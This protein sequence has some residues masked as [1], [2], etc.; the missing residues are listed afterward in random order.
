M[1]SASAALVK[2]DVFDQNLG[3]RRAQWA[4]KENLQSFN[5]IVNYGCSRL[6]VPFED[7]YNIYEFDKDEAGEIIKTKLNSLDD[8]L[9]FGK[10]YLII[11]KRLGND[12]SFF[13]CYVSLN[14]ALDADAQVP[15]C[16]ASHLSMLHTPPRSNQSQVSTPTSSQSSIFNSTSN[17]VSPNASR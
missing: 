12:L 17:T 14:F 11:N 10:E 9:Q 6:N 8:V 7:T 2:M 16:Q 15:T 3:K 4:S 5:E 1:A 13:Y